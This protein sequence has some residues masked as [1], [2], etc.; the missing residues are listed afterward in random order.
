MKFY[1][2][3]SR[4][5]SPLI[6]LLMAHVHLAAQTGSIRITV[7]GVANDRG[8]IGVLLFKT[9]SGFPGDHTKA[10]RQQLV[11][12]GNKTYEFRFDGIPYGTYAVS[13]MHDENMNLKVD[14]NFVGIPREGNGVSNNVRPAMRAP[15]FSEAIFELNSAEWSGRIDL[16]Y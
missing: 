6:F 15:R 2:W 9:E 12:A 13:A 14:T 7:E 8:Q 10:Y 1:S 11:P 5:L 16:I 4:A 3:F